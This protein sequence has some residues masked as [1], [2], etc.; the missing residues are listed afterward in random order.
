MVRYKRNRVND[1]VRESRLAEMNRWFLRDNKNH[2]PQKKIF[3]AALFKAF[4]AGY[5][6]IDK[7]VNY[8]RAR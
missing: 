8:E 6:R 4:Q 7:N 3:C 5:I 1:N 2:L